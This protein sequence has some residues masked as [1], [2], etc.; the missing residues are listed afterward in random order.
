MSYRPHANVVPTERAA[1]ETDWIVGRP[2]ELARLGD[3]V[4][5]ALSGSPRF[6]L[7]EG[8]LGI[9]KSALLSAAADTAE[10][11]GA[12]VLRARGDAGESDL[13]FGVAGQLFEL[14]LDGASEDERRRWLHGPADAVRRIVNIDDRGAGRSGES[15]DGHVASGALYW[16]T[17]N[18]ARRVP[19]VLVVDDLQWADAASLR[20]LIHLSRRMKRLPLAVVAALA[21]DVPES[22]SSLVA[23]LSARVERL[24]LS[25][26]DT[27]SVARLVA[28]HFGVL[29]ADGLAT[30]LLAET[31]GNPLLLRNVLAASPDSPTARATNRSPPCST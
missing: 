5:G 29:P 14:A 1:A 17:A 28:E 11:G 19:L 20:W 27:A 25:A 7:V 24:P 15:L 13:P 8:P 18:A 3:C 23:A 16:L 31:G 9:G 22:T 2:A 26:L 12:R 10:R 6:L 30:R 21:P 4:S